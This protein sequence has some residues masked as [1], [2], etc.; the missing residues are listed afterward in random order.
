[1]NKL[2]CIFV[3]LALGGALLAGEMRGA[4]IHSPSGIEDKRGWDAT[5][6]VL[7]EN[8]YNA[9]FANFA[10]AG[11]ADYPSG[12]V[13]PHPSLYDRDG[14]CRDRLQECLDACRKYGVQLHVWIV[15]CNLGHRTP[16][17]VKREFCADGRVQL[18][19]AGESSTYLAPHLP[20]N[21]ALLENLVAELVTRYPVDGIHLDYIRYPGSKYDFSDSART[22]FE[23]SLGRA[24]TQWPQDC[25]AD[26][27]EH[28]AYQQW[29]RDNITALVRLVRDTVKSL[30]PEVQL[31]AAVY[32]YW[33]GARNG[34]AQDAERWVDE[35]LLDALC[36]MNYSKD[37]WEAGAWLRQQLKAVDGR[38][39]I[40]TGLAN[41]MTPTPEDLAS[42]IEDARKCG[43]DGFVT[44]QLKSEFAD[45]WLP[46]LHQHV[47][48]E[49]VAAPVAGGMRPLVTWAKP[50]RKFPWRLLRF[51][52]RGDRLRCRL[53]WSGGAMPDDL[54][55]RLLH[56]GQKA[57]DVAFRPSFLP[58]GALRLEFTPA[59]RGYYRWELHWTDDDGRAREWRSAS[60]FVR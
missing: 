55:I 49:E 21:Q 2:L 10:W 26:G 18:D 47:I 32:G 22:A 23:Q 53:R 1:M 59:R 14:N 24:V 56:N 41:Y 28:A 39:P 33:P 42:Q 5:V 17:R 58:D 52:R 13:E 3:L 25:Q 6:R 37:A 35:G 9:L 20:E 43:A 16:E 30:R 11:C 44:F 36:P 38:V 57:A 51:W 48:S 46:E 54:K 40:Y 60:R 7:A 31:T 34:I 8:G 12:V 15:V 45:R 4:W 29:R 19:A 50:P 27:K